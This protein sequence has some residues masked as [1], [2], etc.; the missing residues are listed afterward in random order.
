MS[1]L[2]ADVLG[3]R[4]PGLLESILSAVNQTSGKCRHWKQPEVRVEFLTPMAG[5]DAHT[6]VAE[7]DQG[8]PPMQ[9]LG[10]AGI[11]VGFCY[12]HRFI[13]TL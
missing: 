11:T 4:F 3:Y 13:P 7:P 5:E 9:P 1:S 8:H 12:R 6:P 2:R 10:S